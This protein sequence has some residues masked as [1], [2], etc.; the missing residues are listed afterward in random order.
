MYPRPQSPKAS[1][2]NLKSLIFHQQL[3]FQTL[4]KLNNTNKLIIVHGD[5]GCIARLI[6]VTDK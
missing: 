6:W 3:D 5:D 4:N 2:H 1:T